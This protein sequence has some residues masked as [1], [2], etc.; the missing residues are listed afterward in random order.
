MAA[1]DRDRSTRIG[2]LEDR[3]PVTH[4]ASQTLATESV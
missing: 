3:Q 4:K 1:L 2:G